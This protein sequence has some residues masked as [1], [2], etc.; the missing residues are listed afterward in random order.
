MDITF[1]AKTIDGNN[2]SNKPYLR[3]SFIMAS[4]K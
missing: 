3:I 1:C 2:V 4:L